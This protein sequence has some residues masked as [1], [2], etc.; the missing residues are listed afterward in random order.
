MIV[1]ET[2]ELVSLKNGSHTVKDRQTGETFHPVVGPMI[3]ASA[4]H[5]AP[6]QLADRLA[7]NR[8]QIFWDVGLGAAAN[9]IALLEALSKLTHD[10]QI[11]LVS[12]DQTLSPLRFA[13]KNA[14]VLH[15]PKA[16]RG[17]L[18]NLLE[19]GQADITYANR[20]T[21]QWRLIVGDFTAL[22]EA[23]APDAIFYD[24]YSPA[25]NA[26]M[27]SLPHFSRL[28][29]RLS[30]P[31]IL[32]SYS[33]STAVR[34]TLLLAGFFVGTGNATGEKE[35]TT[36]A[37]T[38]LTLLHRPLPSNWLERVRRS[39]KSAPLGEQEGRPI[40]QADWERL[41]SHPQF[42]TCGP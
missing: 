15:Y 25:K 41:V 36:L 32:T 22:P 30:Q 28:R 1:Q 35:E 23:P 7:T 16:W 17:E 9:A 4:I 24:P 38:D 5:I 8:N 37:A 20:G 34:V 26:T 18:V 3:E 19:T 11:Q 29:K 33:R 14:E 31:A 39:T 6:L 10:F 42:A 40:S 13:L 2:F 27:W 21:L 12:F